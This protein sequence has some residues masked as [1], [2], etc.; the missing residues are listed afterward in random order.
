MFFLQAPQ[1]L[2]FQGQTLVGVVLAQ[3]LR[4]LDVAGQALD[5]LIEALSIR[6]FIEKFK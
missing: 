1:F 2:Q 4:K 3:L 6:L 5:K